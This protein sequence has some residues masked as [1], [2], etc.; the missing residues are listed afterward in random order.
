MN[1]FLVLDQQLEGK[2]SLPDGGQTPLCLGCA[3]LSSNSSIP[4]Y[5]I[6]NCL[7]DKRAGYLFIILKGLL[8]LSK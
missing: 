3:L 7:Y 5:S 4:L 8:E 1:I 6:R 2:C